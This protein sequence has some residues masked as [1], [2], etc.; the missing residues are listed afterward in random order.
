MGKWDE[1]LLRLTKLPMEHREGGLKYQDRV[2]IEKGKIQEKGTTALARKWKELRAK[3]D[4][5]EAQAKALRLQLRAYESRLEESFEGE[6]LKK[7]ELEEGGS[8]AYQ[9]EPHTWVKDATAFHEWCLAQ[10]DLPEKM[11]LLWQTTNGIAKEKLE[12]GQPLP[13]GLE[14]FAKPKFVLRGAG[15]AED[16]QA[17]ALF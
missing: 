5:L 3:E 16:A 14:C 15:A 6:G 10:P 7:V 2:N 13:P 11:N 4:S 17:T 12:A 1:V 8:I 9:P